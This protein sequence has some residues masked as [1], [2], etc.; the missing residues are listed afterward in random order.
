M[1]AVDWSLAISPVLLLVLGFPIYVVLLGTAAITLVFFS[2]VPDIALHQA[3]FGS[4]E[5]FALLAI[6]FLSLPVSLC[7]VALSQ[8]VLLTSLMRIRAGSGQDWFNNRCYNDALWR[9]IRFCSG[10]GGNRWP[11]VVTNPS[12]VRLSGS[13]ICRFAGFSRYYRCVDTAFNSTH[14][15]WGRSKRVRSPVVCSR[16]SSRITGCCTHVCTGNYPDPGLRNQ[17]WPAI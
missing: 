2:N 4:V 3:L 8:S 11:F 15:L 12:S 5:S 10:D 1:T 7:P 17:R 13:G 14:C 6:P 9:Y 16:Y